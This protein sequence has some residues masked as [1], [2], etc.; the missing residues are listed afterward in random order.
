MRVAKAVHV[1]SLDAYTRAAIATSTTANAGASI[2]FAVAPFIDEDRRGDVSGEEL[3]DADQSRYDEFCHL[4]SNAALN[5][6]A[7]GQ[8]LGANVVNT[9]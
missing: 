8:K 4:D 9:E 5:T 1:D 7:G 3:A 6:Q 2:G